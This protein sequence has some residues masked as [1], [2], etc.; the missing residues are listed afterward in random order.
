MTSSSS[1]SDYVSVS[2][3]HDYGNTTPC[4]IYMTHEEFENYPG[5]YMICS[6]CGLFVEEKKISTYKKQFKLSLYEIKCLT[7]CRLTQLNISPE[8]LE[9]LKNQRRKTVQQN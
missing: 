1:K 9:E 5:D 6:D 4:I 8:R 7:C 3:E 2:I